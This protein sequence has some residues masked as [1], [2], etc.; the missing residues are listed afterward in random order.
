M[1]VRDRSI[2]RAVEY[3]HHFA[4]LAGAPVRAVALPPVHFAAP[5]RVQDALAEVGDVGIVSL[6]SALRRALEH[7]PGVSR[8]LDAAVAAARARGLVATASRAP[9]GTPWTGPVDED[10][11]WLGPVGRLREVA[12]SLPAQVVVNAHFFAITPDEQPSPHGC[13]GDPAGAFAAHGVLRSLPVSP[14]AT[15]IR[16]GSEWRIV[17]LTIDDVHTTLPGANDGAVVVDRFVRHVD[18]PARVRTPRTDGVVDLVIVDR[19]VVGVHDGGDAPIPPTGCVVRYAAPLPPAALQAVARGA[20]VKHH[21]P[22]HPSLDVAVQGGPWL[23]AD[24]HVICD[25][26]RVLGEGFVTR[27][28]PASPVPGIFPADAASTRAA[29]L[30]VGI[31]GDGELIVVGV[32]GRSSRDGG[33]ADDAR[34]ATLVDLATLLAEAGAIDAMNLDGGGSVQ[35]FV[36]SGPLLAGADRRKTQ[37]AVYERLVPTGLVVR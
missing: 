20:P 26:A 31:R 23:V 32:E 24:A 37:H 22:A 9:D 27:A 25:D 15:L 6:R 16:D 8:T 10:T 4:A 29:R 14:R 12:R 5:A 35:A 13:L 34:G 30:G 33:V 18:H 19:T 2:V 1:R 36:G 11:A 3:A 28:S 21:L 7:G 17:T